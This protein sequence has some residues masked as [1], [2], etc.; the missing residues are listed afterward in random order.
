MGEYYSMGP[1]LAPNRYHSLLED[2]NIKDTPYS[3]ILVGVRYR[4]TNQVLT[5]HGKY[6][7]ILF[8]YDK[9]LSKDANKH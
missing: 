1:V 2:I 5:K 9:T 8:R 3:T 6:D 4:H 7:W